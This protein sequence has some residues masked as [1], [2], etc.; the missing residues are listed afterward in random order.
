MCKRFI[1]IF[2][3]IITLSSFSS[4]S[5]ELPVE[6]ELKLKGF[7]K[8]IEFQ[9]P[10]LQ[11]GAIAI[12]HRGQVIYK[13]TFGNQRGNKMPVTS[14]TLFPLASVS[15]AVSATII[16]LM[17]ERGELSFEETF[18][19]PYLKYP[20]RLAHILGH[21]TGYYFRGNQEIEQ[22]I[23]REKLLAI[24]S[25]KIPKCEPGKYYFYSN[26]VFSLIEEV[27]HSKKLSFQSAIQKLREELKT[28]EIQ[29]LP[30]DKDIHIAYPHSTH[31]IQNNYFYKQLPLPRYYPHIIPS[32][33]GIFASL[34][35]MIE[36][37]KLSFGYRP[38]LISKE[39]LASIQTPITANQDLYKWKIR[40]PYDRNKLESYYG[41]GW[42]ILKAKTHPKT[43]LIFHGGYIAGVGTFI[44][45]IPSQELGIIILTNQ[46][47]AFPLQKGVNFWACFLQ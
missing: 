6:I 9:K 31:I 41:L 39:V 23:S 15:K 14:K 34:D 17:V 33:A 36:I 37:F 25:K 7:I 46:K 16:A 13:T 32:A 18:Q 11:G 29:I 24:L 8:R 47:S 19:L 44:G 35:G 28:D 40:C 2:S 45:F 38:D 27:L 4:A 30:I 12:L 21:T 3:F 1:A 10:K 22:G 5:T 20:V 42:R 26:I 43:E